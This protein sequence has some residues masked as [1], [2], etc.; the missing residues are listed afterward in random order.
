VERERVWLYYAPK[1][2]RGGAA[3]SADADFGLGKASRA[4]VR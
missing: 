1:S 2:L 3:K 4:R